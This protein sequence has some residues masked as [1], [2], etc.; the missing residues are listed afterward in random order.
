[1]SMYYKLV[2]SFFVFTTYLCAAAPS[3][4]EKT[5]KIKATLE[6]FMG[7]D[8]VPLAKESF[9][10]IALLILSFVAGVFV[11]ER[12]IF[13][14]NINVSSAEFMKDVKKFISQN[15]FEKIKNYKNKKF[16]LQA[17]VT[18]IIDN[19]DK[20]K[21]EIYEI[22]EVVKEQQT[23]LL[24]RFI[25][26]LATISSIAPLLG[27]LGTVIGII[28]AFAA[29]ATSSSTGGAAVV[30]KGVSEALVTTALGLVVAIPVLCFF[31]YFSNKIGDIISDMEVNA[32]I[33]IYTLLEKK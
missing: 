28:K 12:F 26:I 19:K 27:L 21:D 2:A 11:I 7:V 14:L 24:N 16:P 20:S 18:T 5:G 29:L 23:R 30:S 3:G 6:Q 32:R 15:S 13:F 8:V 31:N 22:V 4:V 17:I 1:M 9:V 33:V 10:V 25:G